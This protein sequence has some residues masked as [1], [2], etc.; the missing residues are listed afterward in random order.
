MVWNSA[1]PD[2]DANIAE[3][4]DR[5]R[6]NNVALEAALTLEHKFDTGGDQTGRHIIQAFT[7]A[8]ANLESTDST[9]DEWIVLV[10]DQRDNRCW[11]YYD[12]SS[13]S[14]EFLPVDIGTGN[15]PRTDEQSEFT[16]SQWAAWATITVGGGLL[17]MVMDETAAKYA[18]LP[19]SST[20]T[21]SNPTN[22]VADH[23]STVIL[24]LL[25]GGADCVLE[26]GTEYQYANNVAPI[27]D[28][29]DGATN[30]YY[31]TRLFENGGASRYL[32]TGAPGV[33]RT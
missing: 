19:T 25:N 32:V 33:A 21:V 23:N 6:E 11:Y 10:T 31:I 15:V 4:D 12:D 9:D 30:V 20:T 27:F 17:A 8:N 16:V 7:L 18:E 14:G 5:I 2:G 1:L 28:T 24:Q 26:W 13:G 22:I 29:T 3:G